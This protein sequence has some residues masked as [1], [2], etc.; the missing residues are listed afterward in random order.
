MNTFLAQCV[1]SSNIKTMMKSVIILVLYVLLVA[2]APSG[3][4]VLYVSTY[5][6]D[7]VV[8]CF[9]QENL[10]CNCLLFGT[11]YEF[12]YLKSCDL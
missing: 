7:N 9:F 4:V 2:S 12:S 5:Y 11:E 1:G 6:R 3:N 8:M 10:L